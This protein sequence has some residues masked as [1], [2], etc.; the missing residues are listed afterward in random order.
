MLAPQT[1]WLQT[2]SFKD[3]HKLLMNALCSR[4]DEQTLKFGANFRFL[5]F[6]R[7]EKTRDGTLGWFL[8]GE[9]KSGD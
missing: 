7:G 9:A 4:L 1:N 5:G 6:A 2:P 3:L 8:G